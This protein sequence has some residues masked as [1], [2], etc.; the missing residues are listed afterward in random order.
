MAAYD[1]LFQPLAIKSVTI[2]NRFVSTSHQPG[3]AAQGRVTERYLRYEVEKARGGVGLVQFAGATSVSIENCYYYGQLDATTDAIVADLQRMADAIHKHGAVCTAQLTHGGRRERPDIANWI[4]AFGASCRRELKHRA[5]PAALEPRDICRI[6]ADFARAARRVRDGGVDGVEISC[7]PTGIIGQ[8]WSPL[9]NVRRDEF[10]G[11]LANRMRFGL[12]VLERVRAAVGDDYVVGI[13]LSADEMS[14]GG[15]DRGQM[16]EIARRHV[17]TGLVDFVSVVGGHSSDYKS[18]HEMY[19]G[20][21]APG[22]PY[23]DIAR[24]VKEQVDVPLLHAT[25][26]TDAATAAYA[27]DKGIVDLVGMTRAFIADPHHVNK[28]REGREEEVRPC[29]GAAYCVDRVSTGREALCLHNVATSREEHLDQRIAGSGGR[30][31]RVIVVGG[32]PAGLESARIAAAR[33]HEVT[34]FEAGPRLGGQLLLAA[35]GTWRRDLRSIVDWLA[36]EVE[37]LGVQVRLNHLASAEDVRESDPEVVVIATGGLPEVGHFSGAGHA[38]T[39]WDLLSS[40]IEPGREV[41]VFDEAGAHAGLSAAEFIARRGSSVELVTPDRVHGAEV[42][43][44]NIAAHM[45]ELYRAGVRMTTDLRL[46]EVGRRGKR[47]VARLANTFTGD[48]EERVVDQVV[49]DYG[50]TPNDGLYEELKPGSSNLG[51]LDLHALAAFE[52]QSLELNPRAR[53]ALF[54]LGDAWASRNVHA[55]MLDAARVCQ[56]L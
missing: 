47:L 45:S 10:G 12:D 20:M 40:Q 31:R 2:P 8:F 42:G 34:L 52:A 22:A 30:A 32:G 11:S 29:V 4:P 49:G 27:V 51:E 6:A 54:R 39:T 48:V 17:A 56:R 28:L 15:L 50:T 41:L 7:I 35:R 43:V 25:R 36:G 37:R 55:A 14:E 46:C 19:P 23:L 18:T 13:R 44:I 26:I 1:V 53:F 38:L 24:A 33:G 5:F 16:A 3:Y 9:T 21:H